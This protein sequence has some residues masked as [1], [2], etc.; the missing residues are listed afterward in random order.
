MEPMSN[1]QD[2]EQLHPMLLLSSFHG[3][4]VRQANELQSHMRFPE[5]GGRAPFAAGQEEAMACY[6]TDR[7]YSTYSLGC[8][9]ATRKQARNA[10][11]VEADFSASMEPRACA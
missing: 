1:A 2:L 10:L 9:R 4:Q 3:P 6:L 8:N 5:P 11:P 7:K